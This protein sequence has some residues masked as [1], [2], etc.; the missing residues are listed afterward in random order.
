MIKHTHGLSVTTAPLMLFPVY[1]HAPR[2]T[3]AVFFD[4]DAAASFAMRP[5]DFGA[6][7]RN[8]YLAEPRYDRR[9]HGYRFEF[10]TSPDNKWPRIAA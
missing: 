6:E 7:Q 10:G 9:S 2:E 8:L 5:T 3:I 4:Y 1:G